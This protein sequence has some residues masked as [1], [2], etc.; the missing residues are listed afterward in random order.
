MS[1]KVF[2]SLTFLGC[3]SLCATSIARTEVILSRLF[4]D[5][6]VLQRNQPI[7]IWEWASPGEIVR[8]DF[9]GQ[10]VST[11]ADKKGVWQTWL[12]PESAGGPYDLL[13]SGDKTRVPIKRQDIL[14]GDVWIASGQSNMEFP[15]TG[16]T[17][18]PL[19]NGTAEIAAAN[20]PRLRLL[21]QEKIMSDYPLP[22]ISGTWVTCSP[23]TAAGFSAVAY[24]FGKELLEHEKVPIG[25]IQTAWGGTPAQSW[26][27]PE[28]ISE[29]NLESVYHDAGQIALDVADAHA[30]QSLYAGEDAEARAANKPLPKHPGIPSEALGPFIPG[31]LFNAMIAPYTRYSIKGVIWY[32]G[33]T[34][35]DPPRAPYYDRVFP[36]LIRDWRRQ[37]AEG[38]F[39]FLFVQISSFEAK[40]GNWGAVRD[41][42]RKTLSLRNTAM[43]VTLDIGSKKVIHPPDK[44]T[45]SARLATAARGMVYG[46]KLK[47]E[48]PTFERATVEGNT[49]RVWLSHAEGLTAKETPLS[50]FEVAGS[51]LVY[52]PAEAKIEKYGGAETIVVSS[53]D[54][55]APLYVRYGW[56]PYVSG[57]I[58]NDAGLPLGTFSSRD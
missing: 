24:F 38:D 26:I 43:A 42:Q 18:Q 47:W 53:S 5:H 32:Q 2:L 44:Q 20:E 50:D 56:S 36:A 48:A 58:Y 41:A 28:G 8:V 51:D 34:D 57:Y 39:P 6:A 7:R 55:T 23:A 9:H 45:V 37:W 52:H 40:T 46:E 4:S 27:S 33:E 11:S 14:I 16:W 21:K 25:L 1:R 13:V 17:N 31:V 19:K 49:V 15:L 54:V 12:R 30:Q 22:D 3:F 35:R 10:S 29:A